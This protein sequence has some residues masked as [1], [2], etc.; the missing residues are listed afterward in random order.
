MYTD[1]GIQPIVF[2]E[3]EDFEKKRK[4]HT[5]FPYFVIQNKKLVGDLNRNKNDFFFLQTTRVF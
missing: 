5:R 3:E 2:K 1:F 4:R